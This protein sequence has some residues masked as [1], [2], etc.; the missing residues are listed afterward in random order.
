[1]ISN[2]LQECRI[3]RFFDTKGLCL[4]YKNNVLGHTSILRPIELPFHQQRGGWGRLRGNDRGT[5]T[6]NWE[7]VSFPVN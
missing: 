5:K 1:M 6:G 3:L 2:V 4:V 7:E